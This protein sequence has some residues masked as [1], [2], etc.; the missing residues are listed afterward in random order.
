MHV[1]AAGVHHRHGIPFGIGG[2]DVAGIGQAGRLLDRQR[3]HVGAQ[4]DGRAVAVAQQAD[5]AGLADARRHL[6]AGGRSRP[7]RDAG[8]SR[9]LHRQLGMRVHV[10]VERLE[11]REQIGEARQERP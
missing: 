3:I 2:R 9:L 1:V 5:D 4:H 8:R 6:V 10:L 7:Q 11:I